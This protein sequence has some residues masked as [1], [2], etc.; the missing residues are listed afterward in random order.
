MAVQAGYDVLMALP[1]GLGAVFICFAYNSVI[2]CEKGIIK[3]VYTPSVYVRVR[4][5]VCVR[6]FTYETPGSDELLLFSA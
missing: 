2:K 3:C 4:A 5:C 1:P 6:M